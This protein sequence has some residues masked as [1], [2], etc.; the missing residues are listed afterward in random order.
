M[1]NKQRTVKTVDGG[2]VFL[3][4]AELCQELG[5]TPESDFVCLTNSGTITFTKG[6]PTNIRK[7][8][9]T[10]K[11]SRFIPANS[12]IKMAY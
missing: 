9:A 5:F 10:V 7:L 6:K 1:Y 12:L 11:T 4:Y 8:Y 3:T 2:K